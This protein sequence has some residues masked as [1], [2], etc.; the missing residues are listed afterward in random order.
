[1]HFKNVLFVLLLSLIFSSCKKEE[2]DFVIKGTVTDASFSVP[3]QGVN[4]K[5]YSFPLGSTLGVYESGATTDAQGN[6]SFELEREKYEKIQLV[7]EKNNYFKIINDVSFSNL[8][9]EEDNIINYSI[10]AKSWTRFVI[11]NQAPSTA[12]DE[13]KLFKNSG[14]ADC[15]EC[16]SNGYSYYYGDVDTVIYCPNNANQY[17]SFFYWVNGNQMNGNDSVYN[18]PFDTTTYDFYY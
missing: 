16:C 6:Y 8:T 17:M 13:F 7:L 15:D 11:Q 1:M 10:Q 4:V 9:S 12:Q 14:K 18:T 2:L 3:A 5:L